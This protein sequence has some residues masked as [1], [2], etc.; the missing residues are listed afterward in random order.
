[1]PRRL[2]LPLLVGAI[3]CILGAPSPA[4]AL[5]VYP[6][7]SPA[8]L[9]GPPPWTVTYKFELDTGPTPETVSFGGEGDGLSFPSIDGPGTVGPGQA[10]DG[11]RIVPCPGGRGVQSYPAGFGYSETIE[12]PA[13]ST[14]TLTVTGVRRDPLPFGTHDL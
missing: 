5:E 3:T 6:S 1:M 11:V 8:V 10:I 9:S 7:Y 13:A 12:L 4:L 14:T 2:A